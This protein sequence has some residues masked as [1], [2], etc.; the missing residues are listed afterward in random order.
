[1]EVFEGALAVDAVVAPHDSGAVVAPGGAVLKVAEAD[2]AFVGVGS[3]G[4]DSVLQ[5]LKED[6]FEVEGEARGFFV[7][8]GPGYPHLVF[9]DDTVAVVE[10]VDSAVL[11]VDDE[12]PD[13]GHFSTRLV[14]N[15]IR[16]VEKTLVDAVR[17]AFTHQGCSIQGV[18]WWRMPRPTATA[19]EA[20]AVATIGAS[21]RVIFTS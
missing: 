5:F 2:Q 6:V 16:Q 8:V 15:R 4:V 19:R 9:G 20:I 14:P 1:V 17:A 11:P 21:S 13:S 12:V 7:F 10:D 3:G 18:P